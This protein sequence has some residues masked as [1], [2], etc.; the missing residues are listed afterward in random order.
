MLG[1]VILRLK[2][3]GMFD[4][5]N[6]VLMNIVKVGCKFFGGRGGVRWR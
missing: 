1:V 6:E 2:I 3:L 4:I 5:L